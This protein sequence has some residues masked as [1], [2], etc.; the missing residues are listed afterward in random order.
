MRR[1]LAIDEQSYGTEHPSVARDLNN[2][3]SLL[4]ETNRLSEAEPLFRRA[5]AIDEQSYGGVHPLVAVKLWCLAVLLRD[6]NRLGEAQR[7]MQRAKVIY[8]QFE[9]GNGF[10]HPHWVRFET[11][12]RQMRNAA[13]GE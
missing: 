5:L 9:V 13:D 10:E 4:Q 1:A 7:L 8:E 11:H 3:A 2:L 12:Y 6:T